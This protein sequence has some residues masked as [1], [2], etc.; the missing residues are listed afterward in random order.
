LA[1]AEK[2]Y[3]RSDG[4]TTN[5]FHEYK[6]TIRHVRELY[7]LSP[8]RDFGPLALKA[9]RQK[10]INAGWC[11]GFINQRIGRVRRMFKW[12]ASEE[13]VP[14]AVYQ[15]LSTVSGLQRGR[16]TARETE[17]VGPVDEAVVDATIQHLN[18]HVCGLVEFQR[19]TGCRPGEA[20]TRTPYRAIA[21]RP[22]V[23]STRRKGEPR[24]RVEWG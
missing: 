15:A 23:D 1:H 16:T 19:L 5:E 11:R 9:V 7:G 14:P 12:A 21:T 4:S 2:H 24:R 22:G 13:L 18:R 10:F 20:C 3:R 17:P 8:A 6:L